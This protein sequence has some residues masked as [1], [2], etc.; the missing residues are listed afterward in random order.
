MFGSIPSFIPYLSIPPYFSSQVHVFC[1]TFNTHWVHVMRMGVGSSSRARLASQDL[2]SEETDCLSPS[3]HQLPMA[4]QLGVGLHKPLT[5][6]CWD[7]GWLHLVRAVCEFTCATVLFCS[8]DTVLL[9]TSS[10]ALTLLPPLFWDD[11]MNLFAV[12]TAWQ[13]IFNL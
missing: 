3:S 4:I 2:Y 10:L 5:H 1:L 7:F 8:T 6:P 13:A 9:Q 11:L 12:I